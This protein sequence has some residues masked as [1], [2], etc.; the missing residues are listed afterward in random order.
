MPDTPIDKIRLDKLA[1]ER[2][3]GF[4]DNRLRVIAWANRVRWDGDAFVDYDFLTPPVTEFNWTF[5]QPREDALEVAERFR[6]P[7]EE[8]P[9]NV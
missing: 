1:I 7:S 2:Y 5:A 8:E 4:N 9:P 3:G 6:I